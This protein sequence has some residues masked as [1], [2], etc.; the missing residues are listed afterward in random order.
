[1]CGIYGRIGR[2]NDELDTRAT[3]SLRHR[4]PDDVGLLVDPRGPD[5]QVVVLGHTRLSILDLSPAGHQPMRSDDGRF[6]LVFNGEIYNYQA[7]K[8]Q[9]VADG[10]V[11]HSTTD[12]E[13]VL[14]LFEAKGEAA[15]HD[16]EGMYAIALWDRV[17]QSLL[18]AR[19]P[20]GIK[21][22]YWRANGK[23]SLA[24]ASELKALIVDPEI[25]REP[26]WQ[27]LA[28]Y[29]AY[30]YVPT[31]RTALQDLHALAPGHLLKWQAGRIDLRRFHRFQLQPKLDVRDFA[32]ATERLER[33]LLEVV[34]EH[35][36]ADVPVG[37]FLSGGIDS[38]LLVAM[39]AR[40]KRERGDQQKLR[41][42]T[43]AFGSEGRHWDESARAAAIARHLDV[44]H[45]IV[46]VDPAQAEE[47]FHHLV[48]QFDEP[49]A[50]PTAVAHDVLCQ[51]AR[52]QVTVALAGDGGDEAFAGYPRHRATWLLGLWQRM[53][54]QLRRGLTVAESRLPE[55]AE[56]VPLLRQARRFLRT[57]GGSLAEVYRDWSTFHD[58]AGLT[59][60]LTPEALQRL[61][62]GVLPADLGQTLAAL[63][64]VPDAS[65]VDAACYA[66]LHGF[67]PDNVLRESDRVSMRHALEVRVPLADRR[68][69]QFGLQLPVAYKLPWTALL[70]RG[71]GAT[72][73]KR[74]LRAVAARWLP[75]DVVRAPKQG[76]GAPMGAWL[77]GPMRPLLEHA[78]DPAVLARRG[79]VRPEVARQLREEHLSGQR[80]RTWPLWSLIVLES[81]F[82][83]RIDRLDV[84]IPQ[85]VR[86]HIDVVA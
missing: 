46:P 56:A 67:L 44:A 77:S 60:L 26:D 21:P 47:R 72:E 22:L 74:V 85:G 7:L 49:F 39:M 17:E 57:G 69:V 55:R 5:G 14:R 30:L 36:T 65:P 11:F 31:P 27:A 29:L 40:L 53:P 28:G 81:W 61:P 10:A 52:E 80:D 19:D 25:A 38:G 18:L 9:L 64:E 71:G 23:D 35:M 79:L 34:G 50:N 42:F 20:V 41:T 32:D 54:G 33:L 4:G 2:R 12:T 15:L 37:A 51:Q 13:V 3:L 45:T 76:F 48:A 62:G 24:F 75:Q 16:L 63:A 66:D 70:R 6:A 59:R 82:S 78:T 58:A 84:A 73:S 86:V 68:V 1:M 83:Q 8:R 43:V